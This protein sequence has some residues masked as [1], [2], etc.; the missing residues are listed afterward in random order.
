MAWWDNQ[1]FNDYL[2]RFNEADGLNSSRRWALYQFTRLIADIPG[3]TAE[4]GVFE[5]AGSYAI[6]SAVASHGRTPRQHFVFD[7]FEG[8]SQPASFDGDAWRAGDL[9]RGLDVVRAN[10]AS[11]ENVRYHKGWI[12]E[13]FQ[14]VESSTSTF[15]LVHID[16]DLYQPTLD[17]IQFFYPRTNP[18]GLIV[19]DDYG[20]TTCPGATQAVDEFLASRREK[21]VP[22]PCGGGFMLKGCATAAQP[23][24]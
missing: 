20:F 2:A 3:D 8:L 13:V 11:F 19:C 17:S 24:L 12:P 18:G 21:M 6:C 23:G 15:A 5:G 9:C 7:S 10:L 1:W 16:V 4:C 14:Q 22:L